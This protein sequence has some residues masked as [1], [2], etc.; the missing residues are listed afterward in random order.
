MFSFIF[1]MKLCCCRR[2]GLL[3]FL[4][5]KD[6]KCNKNLPKIIGCALRFSRQLLMDKTFPAEGDDDT[7]EALAL[8][9]EEAKS[10]R[11]C[12]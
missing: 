12:L 3:H 9:R 6:K 2:F 1:S 10:R 7:G 5:K 8:K 4:L 11:A